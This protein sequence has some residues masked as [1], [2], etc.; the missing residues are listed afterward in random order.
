MC[1]LLNKSVRVR[2]VKL[3][4]LDI[5]EGGFSSAREIC[6][7]TKVGSKNVDSGLWN[8]E[9]KQVIKRKKRHG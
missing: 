5:N 8:D 9:G 4:N 1:V 3:N 2:T 7:C 6:E